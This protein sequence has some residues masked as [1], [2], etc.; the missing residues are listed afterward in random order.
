MKICD[1]LCF[2]AKNVW[3]ILL[4]DQFSQLWYFRIDQIGQYAEGAVNIPYESFEKLDEKKKLNIINAGYTVFARYGYDKASV[5]EITKAAGISKGS[6]FYYFET[7]KNFFIYLY[8]YSGNLM[9][10]LV[11]SPDKDGAPA[12]MAYT[13]F[14]ERLNAVYL[15]K[16]K[17][18]MDYPYM[19]S[20]LKKIVFDTS[21]VAQEVIS[22]INRKYIRERGM[23][24]LQGLDYYKFKE[25]IDPAM[26]I[27]LLTWCS[28]GCVNQVLAEQAE[29]GSH[30]STPDFDQVAKLYMKYVRM[31][32]MSFYKEEYLWYL[33]FSIQ[34]KGG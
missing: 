10:K 1:F 16:I 33:F 25:G 23:A 31:F 17:A 13:D 6:L 11:D 15:L 9:Q 34:G 4:I 27:Q 14:F 32:R 8:E 5:D 21:H 24:F 22:D 2:S 19:A 12:Y 18:G 3:I 29:T 7:K 20:F 30:N 28:E 26:V